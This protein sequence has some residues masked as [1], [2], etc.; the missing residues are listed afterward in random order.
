MSRPS[1]FNFDAII[2]RQNTASAKWDRYQSPDILPMWLADMDFESPPEILT[3]LHQ[4]VDHGVF[5]YSRPSDDLVDTVLARLKRQYRW[6]VKKDSLVWLPG[7]VTGI[8]VTCRAVGQQGDNVLTTVPVYAPV[9][10]APGLRGRTLTTARMADNQKRWEIDFDRLE[11]AVTARTRLFIL[12]NPHNP[13]GRVFSKDELLE[14]VAFCETHNL[15]ICSDEIHCDLILDSNTDSGTGTGRTHIP[16]ATLGPEVSNRTITL[17][18]PSKTFNIAGLGCS[19]AIIENPT[20]RK[21]FKAAMAGIV[22]D[23]NALA[24]TAAAAA[25][26]HGDRW[27]RALLDYLRKNRDVVTRAVSAMPGLAMNPIEA[28]YLAWI[29]TRSAHLGNPAKFFEKAGVGLNNGIDFDGSGFVRLNFGCPRTT[30]ETGLNRMAEAM[31]SR[32]EG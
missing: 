19:F 27:L 25:Y 11:D 22:P 17:M 32:K 16:A 9:R 14:L 18:A 1:D 15:V 7:L 28:T 30:L 2:N 8:N 24:F 4:R 5:G 12:C 10:S 29:D 6:V 20:L 21:Q 26:R 13:T 3:A 31:A 23:V